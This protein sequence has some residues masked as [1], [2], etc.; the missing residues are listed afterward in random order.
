LNIRRCQEELAKK[1]FENGETYS[2][3]LHAWDAA[4]IYYEKSL[5]ILPDSRVAGWAHARI[6]EMYAEKG[7]PELASEAQQKLVEY[8]TPERL[9][10]DPELR[11][12]LDAAAAAIGKARRRQADVAREAAAHSS[13]DSGES[14]LEAGAEP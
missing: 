3:L 10:A 14:A 1:E 6:A 2:K 7:D 8:A 4:L 12:A 13:K 5:E 11:K 9:Q